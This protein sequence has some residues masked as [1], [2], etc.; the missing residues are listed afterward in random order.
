MT[1]KQCVEDP[2]KGAL[3]QHIA[4]AAVTIRKQRRMV[5]NARRALTFVRV[6][7]NNGT[8]TASF[9]SEETPLVGSYHFGYEQ[10]AFPGGGELFRKNG[11]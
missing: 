8:V 10:H 6:R 3:K 4:M 5:S 7:R 9:V 1:A 2:Y 11:E